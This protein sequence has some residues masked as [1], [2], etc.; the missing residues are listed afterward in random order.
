MSQEQLYQRYLPAMLQAKHEAEKQQLWQRAGPEVRYYID[1][2][3]QKRCGEGADKLTM[4]S[5]ATLQPITWPDLLTMDVAYWQQRQWR[6]QQQP[7]ASREQLSPL[8]SSSTSTSTSTSQSRL[9]ASVPPDYI[10][11]YVG[12]PIRLFYHSRLVYGHLYSALHYIVLHAEH[13]VQRWSQAHFPY[14]WPHEFYAAPTERVPPTVSLSDG[15]DWIKP[16][17]LAHCEQWLQTQHFDWLLELNQALNQQTAAAYVIEYQDDK[18]FPWVDFVCKNED[19][20][21]L[22]RPDHFAEDIDH[23][24]ASPDYLSHHVQQFAAQ[25]EKQCRDVGW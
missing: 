3:V 7:A 1:S 17:F 24:A 12:E 11:L 10:N 22:V 19:A 6:P 4:N 9:L 23:I 25:L 20:L 2:E 14:Q 21:R 16:Y 8:T 18:G 5:H 13:M 15:H